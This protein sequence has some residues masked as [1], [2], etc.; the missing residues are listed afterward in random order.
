MKTKKVPQCCGDSGAS[1]D[2]NKRRWPS[3]DHHDLWNREAAWLTYVGII[4]SRPA[5]AAAA[6]L[7]RIII[8]IIIIQTT[9][10]SLAI[11]PS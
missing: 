8:I 10:G 2:R 3:V 6:N 9:K 11:S 4:I 1:C 5:A 7:E